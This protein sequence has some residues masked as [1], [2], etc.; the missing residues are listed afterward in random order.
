VFRLLAYLSPLA[1]GFGMAAA[2]ALTADRPAR[3][4]A[5]AAG[6]VLAGAMILLALAAFTESFGAFVK[7]SILVASFSALVAALYLLGEAFGLP[8]EISQIVAGLV[9]VALMS[10]VFW[11]GPMIREAADQTQGATY[12][13]ITAA[14]AV[15]PH[16]VMGYSVFGFNPLHSEP[17]RPLGLH[18][19]QFGY[20]SWAATSAGYALAA[21]IGFGVAAGVRIL[22]RRMSGDSPQR[23]E[24]HREEKILQRPPVPPGGAGLSSVAPP[25]SAKEGGSP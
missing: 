12:R 5:A 16:L 6:A 8:R 22:R 14:I 23:H 20:P 10:T 9:V 13:R 25:Q 18:D 19:Y 3:R 7:V 11:A 2:L 24:V 1:V 4:R 15:N 21:L 17:L